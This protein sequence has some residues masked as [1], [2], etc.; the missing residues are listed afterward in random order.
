VCINSFHDLANPAADT[1]GLILGR[2][3]IRDILSQIDVATRN[4]DWTNLWQR[5]I[6]AMTLPGWAAKEA[7]T[8]QARNPVP[9]PEFADLAGK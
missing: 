1:P 5:Q 7:E 3:Q 4:S 8:L 6:N 9:Y 2:A